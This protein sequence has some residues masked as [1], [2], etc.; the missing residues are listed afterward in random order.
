MAS[1]F[2]LSFPAVQADG[3]CDSV[4]FLAGVLWIW[5]NEYDSH[6]SFSCIDDLVAAFAAGVH[7]F[8]RSFQ[9]QYSQT[10]VAVLRLPPSVGFPVRFV[11]SPPS[12]GLVCLSQRGHLSNGFVVMGCTCD[13]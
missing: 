7:V 3:F 11:Y 8:T 10:L 13:E 6:A 1:S 2:V 4:G 5:R 9:P 12:I